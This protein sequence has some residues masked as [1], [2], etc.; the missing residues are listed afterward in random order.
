MTMRTFLLMIAEGRTDADY[1]VNAVVNMGWDYI[2]SDLDGLCKFSMAPPAM[3]AE[4]LRLAVG[5][6]IDTETL[7]DTTHQAFLRGYAIER[8]SGFGEEDY[9]LPAEAHEPLETSTLEYFN[10]KEFFTG[11]QERI[12]AGLDADAEARGFL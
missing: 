7:M 11:V 5:L 1:W 3:H 12:L 4:A 8:R 2:R 6:D 10:T 9:V